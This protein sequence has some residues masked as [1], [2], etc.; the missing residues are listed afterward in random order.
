MHVWALLSVWWLPDGLVTEEM[1][2]WVS[3]RVGNQCLPGG[4]VTEEKATWDRPYSG[5]RTC[6][7]EPPGSREL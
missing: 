7:L 1:V 5:A 3:L 6:K 2:T 4:L